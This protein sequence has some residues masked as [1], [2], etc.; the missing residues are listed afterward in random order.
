[1]ENKQAIAI[2]ASAAQKW[3]LIQSIVN[4]RELSK[5]LKEIAILLLV[6]GGDQDKILDAVEKIRNSTTTRDEALCQ[7]EK[8][9]QA[10]QY[11]R[12][13]VAQENTILHYSEEYLRQ[14]S[15]N[16]AVD[17][18]TKPPEEV[19]EIKAEDLKDDTWFELERR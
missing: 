10:L 8:A 16:E 9:E 6:R 3:M 11:A 5:E 1:M 19:I 2:T 17:Q 13:L 7:A 15:L 12:K 14:L 4:T 18:G